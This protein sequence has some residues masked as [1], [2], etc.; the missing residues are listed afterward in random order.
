MLTVLS[1]LLLLQQQQQR[2]AQIAALLNSS[3]RAY[4]P[5]R[6]LF[7]GRGWGGIAVLLNKEA[8]ALKRPALRTPYIGG[9]PAS[10]DH[11]EEERINKR[12][13]A[14]QEEG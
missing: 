8:V 6:Y 5:P 4:K 11:I 12:K 2:G 14:S 1:L 3:I 13:A 10:I 9:T 7:A